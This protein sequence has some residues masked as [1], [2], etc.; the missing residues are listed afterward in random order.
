MTTKDANNS[1]EP[2]RTFDTQREVFFEILG[3]GYFRGEG[4]EGGGVRKTIVCCESF[5]GVGGVG[6]DF[7]N[8]PISAF[9]LSMV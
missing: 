3:E 4:G 1:V 5:G 2:M 8:S 6:G 7:C 9:F